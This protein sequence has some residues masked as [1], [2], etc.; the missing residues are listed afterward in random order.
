MVCKKAGAE[1]I[2]FLD[3]ASPDSAAIPGD[4]SASLE[5][6]LHNLRAIGS[7]EKF[8]L[9]E[10]PR[11]DS[12]GFVAFPSDVDPEVTVHGFLSLIQK[13]GMGCSRYFVVF[14]LFDSCKESFPFRSSVR[15]I[16]M[17]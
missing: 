6:E 12:C 3:R 4:M 13:S 7:S 15:P 9:K 16:S 14:F 17:T 8:S 1:L 10:I 5:L 11:L 2:S